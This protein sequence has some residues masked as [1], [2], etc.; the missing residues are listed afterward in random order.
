M[1]LGVAIGAL[2]TERAW[3]LPAAGASPLDRWAAIAPDL[4][5]HVAAVGYDPESGRLTVYPESTSWATKLRLEQV[6][7]IKAANT[8]GRTVVRALRIFAPTSVPEPDDIP[9]APGTC[10]VLRSVHCCV[11]CSRSDCR[12]RPR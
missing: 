1:G 2:V 9:P 11:A 6:R 3:E 7:L 10:R 4:A 8:R 12:Y 5:G